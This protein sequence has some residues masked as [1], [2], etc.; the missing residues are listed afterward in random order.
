MGNEIITEI[1]L[2]LD[3]LRADLK[4]GEKEAAD[5][6]KRGGKSFG[7]SVEAGMSKGFSSIRNQFLGL[8]ATLGAAFTGKA[9]ISAASEQEKA[10]NQRNAAMA[11]SGTFSDMAAK[12]ADRFADSLQ[13]TTTAQDDVVQSGQ[14]TLVTLGRLSGEGLDRAT[15]A[16]LDFSSTG[17]VSTEQ[18]FT[19]LGKAANGNVTAL[20]K[21]GLS[22]K[23]T[24]D[25][26]RDFQQALRQLE[27]QFGGLAALQTNTFAG[28][29]TQMQNGF[30]ELLESLGNIVVKSPTAIAFLKKMTTTFFDL[31][32][33]VT[34]F[35]GNR[36]MVGEFAK[37]FLQISMIITENV[38][39]IIELFFKGVKNGFLAIQT[40]IFA[41][42][43][44][45]D[46]DFAAA[47]KESFQDLADNSA[48]IFD[49]DATQATAN[50]IAKMQTFTENVKPVAKANFA[51]I[52]ASAR[53]GMEP[54]LESGWS[55][56]V[57]GFSMAFGKVALQ[58]DSFK[59]QLQNKLTGAFA[60]FRD[61][62][63]NAFASIG[64]ALAKGED[65]FVAFRNA[66]WG[67]FGDLAIQIGQFYF[68][69]GLANL[70]LNPAAAAAQIAGGLALI[71]LGGALKA[72]SGGG[73]AQPAG[74][75]VAAGG[76]SGSPPIGD[77]GAAFQE[78]EPQEPQ[79]KIDLVIQ[80]NVMDRRETGLAIVDV[81]QE[82]LGSN[83]LV[84]TTQ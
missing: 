20:N 1:R 81:L 61:G 75:G 9:L 22:I 56:M 23:S 50:F 26:T 4:L 73:G 45:F 28:A 27:R 42:A 31:A 68:L 33:A 3:K 19:L 66:I 7:D 5:S 30:G 48:K 55:F 39:P 54:E 57:Q 83:G 34:K 32:E 40:G 79:T 80:G 60:N 46:K 62:V 35:V 69:M 17:L 59:A 63:G 12:S 43:G 76:G 52:A 53:A 11:V 10:I 44:L 13:R 36:D 8:V 29:F 47:A 16:A 82:A 65:A 58:S 78:T 49:F 2:E 38:G 14:A 72:F 41:I 70:F 77:V 51:G 74:G 24:G 18:A 25:D 84:V 15:K 21:F 67:V 71:V 37:S 64:S 6:G